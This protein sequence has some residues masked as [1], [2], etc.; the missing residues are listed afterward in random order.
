[1]DSDPEGTV[2]ILR[3]ELY[4]LL[5]GLKVLKYSCVDEF[6]RFLETTHNDE[7]HAQIQKLQRQKD[8]MSNLKTRLIESPRPAL[9]L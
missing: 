5:D 6:S 4:E 3:S 9:S 2:R 8:C 1:M 7:A